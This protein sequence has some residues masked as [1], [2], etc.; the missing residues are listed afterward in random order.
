[1]TVR[2]RYWLLDHTGTGDHMRNFSTSA[3]D[4]D[5]AFHLL[6]ELGDPILTETDAFIDIEHA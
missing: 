1:M 3:A 6:T 4:A 2:I 5:A